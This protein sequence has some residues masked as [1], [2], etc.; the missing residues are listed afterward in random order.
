MRKG[1]NCNVFFR[2][3]LYS[4]ESRVNS[5][6]VIDNLLILFWIFGEVY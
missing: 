5:R 3:S 6:E 1:I 2:T 4:I